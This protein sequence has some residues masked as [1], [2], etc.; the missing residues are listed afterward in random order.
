MDFK[1]LKPKR[2]NVL[3]FTKLLK[4]Y[5]TLEEGMNEL[6]KKYRARYNEILMKQDFE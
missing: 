2:M 3:E 4:R 5:N 1:K 6:M